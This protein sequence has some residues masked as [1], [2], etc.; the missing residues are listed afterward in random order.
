MRREGERGA[1][2]ETRCVVPIGLIYLVRF[3]HEY[4]SENF[5]LFLMH[6]ENSNYLSIY[7]YPKSINYIHGWTERLGT[8]SQLTG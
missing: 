1:D 7:A 8:A 4:M 6:T 2:Y 3:C 5:F